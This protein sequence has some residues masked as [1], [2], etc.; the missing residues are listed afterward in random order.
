MHIPYYAR[1]TIRSALPTVP[2][3]RQVEALDCCLCDKPFGGQ[4]PVPLGPTMARDSPSCNCK[5]TPSS[6]LIGAATS[7]EQYSLTTSLSS[8]SM[9]SC[10]E[11]KL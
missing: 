9:V 7:T 8:R 5:F 6:A 2:T 1:A 4:L 11:F 3:S 10:L